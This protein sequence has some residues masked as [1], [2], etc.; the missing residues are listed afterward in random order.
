MLDAQKSITLKLGEPVVDSDN[1]WADDLLARQD[2]AGRLTNLVATQE[3]P[4]TISL[5]GQWGTGKTFMLKRWQK[6]LELD[7]YQA[8]YFNAWEDDFCDDP[9]LAMIGQLSEHFKD[10]KFKDLARKAVAV[11]IPLIRENLLGVLKA[12]TG[13]TINLDN[14]QQEN[15]TPFDAYLEQIATKDSFKNQLGQLA[16]LVTRDTGHPLVFIVDE[17]DR[18]RPTFAI[19][20]LERVKHIFDVP[21]IVFV[22]G[23]NRDELC[24]SLQSVYGKIQADIYLRRFF[25]LEFSLPAVDSEAF[26]SHL[27][28]KYGLEEF[29]HQLS[30]N[31][32]HR[33]HADE[34]NWLATYVPGLWSR[35]EL[36]LR[37]I[38]YCIRSIALVGRN[39]RQRSYMYPWLLA[40]LIPVKLLNGS[41]YRQF[42]EGNCHASEVMDYIHDL[43]RLQG[44]DSR[45]TNMLIVMEAY[46]YRAEFGYADFGSPVSSPWDQLRLLK[47]GE[48]LTQAEYLSK[49]T[50]AAGSG[51]ADRLIEIINSER[52]MQ[53]P[54]ETI[55]YV[56]H[57]IDLHQGFVRR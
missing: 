13:L 43:P 39:L 15:K 27:M 42:I 16:E 3:P 22:F 12:T 52:T 7:K 2:I 26:A 55:K 56:A 18:C 49:K 51:R 9:F 38:D 37:D 48:P 20:L 44:L 35:F 25:D 29:F 6:T 23:V 33:V 8:I 40:L 10:D 50:R 21:N 45:S 41:L 28:R 30:E 11:A 19:E 54:G 46:L 31:A 34:F 14:Q 5:H 24:T 47:N 17:L 1:P 36:S 4:L 32:D 57:L 53:E